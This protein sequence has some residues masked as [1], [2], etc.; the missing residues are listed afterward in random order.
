MNI[1]AVEHPAPSVVIVTTHD[2]EVKLSAQAK[3]WT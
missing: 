2:T 1:V 3:L